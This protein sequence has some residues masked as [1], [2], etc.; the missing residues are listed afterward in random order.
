MSRLLKNSIYTLNANIIGQFLGIITY[1]IVPNILGQRR[2][3]QIVFISVLLSFSVLFEFGFQFVYGRLMPYILRKN[4]QKEILKYNSTFF[5]IRL[6]GAG[7]GGIILGSI[8]YLRYRNLL[9]SFLLML[10]II[11]QFLFTFCIQQFTVKEDFRMYQYFNIQYSVVKLVIIPFTYFLYISGWIAAQVVSLGCVLSQKRLLFII[12]NLIFS[13][14][15]IDTNI[16][17]NHFGEA[18]LLIGNFFLW[19]QLLNSGRLWASMYYPDKLLSQYGL[20]NSEYS[21]LQSLIISI[22]LPVSVKIYK[23]VK[24]DPSYAIDFLATLVFR[25]NFLFFLF[26]ALAIFVSPYLFSHFFAKFVIDL[27]VLKYMMLSILFLPVISSFGSLFI[28]VGKPIFL[29][30]SYG[31]GFLL[32]FLI[33]IFFRTLID[34]ASIAQLCGIAFSSFSLLLCTFYF[35]RKKIN[36]KLYYSFKILGSQVIYLLLLLIFT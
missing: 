34:G 14:I 25:I 8:Y 15:Q 2:Y 5:W 29:I 13:N 16:I 28:G 10:F 3:A 23:I 11:L 1:L 36:R 35:F 12:K 7:L 33:A 18:L 21:I 31:S 24:E 22:F 20:I 30:F 27:N 4:S 19:R 6:F 32:S 26:T 9:V 17:K